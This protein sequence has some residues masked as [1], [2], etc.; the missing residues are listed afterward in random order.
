MIAAK[1]QPQAGIRHGEDRYYIGERIRFRRSQRTKGIENG[2]FGTVVG[3][4]P[5]SRTI[6]VRLDNEPSAE[7]KRK[8]GAGQIA[9]VSLLQMT[10]E[11]IS[12][13]YASTT[14]SVQGASY[15][16]TWVLLDGGYTSKELAYTQLSRGRKSTRLFAA[17]QMDSKQEDLERLTAKLE[18]ITKKN[19][20]H[21]V[22]S[23]IEIT[24][25]H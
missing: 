13:G 16:H 14:H 1:A 5:I 2:D 11:D 15:D 19:L 18:N 21:D 25:E 8:F 9:T 17:K 7:S 20:A 10:K 24:H 3:V 22:M 4:N 6:N 23:K 12:L